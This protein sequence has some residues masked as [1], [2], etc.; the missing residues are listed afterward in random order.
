MPLSL[1]ALICAAS[2]RRVHRWRTAL[3]RHVG[4]GHFGERL[5][6]ILGRDVRAAPGAGAA[7]IDRLALHR[8]KKF[9]D[10]VDLHGGRHGE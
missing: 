8:L 2:E 3:E 1:P 4:R 5:Q 7:E 10:I 9:A 6:E